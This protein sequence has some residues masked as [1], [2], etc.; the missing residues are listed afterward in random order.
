MKK[1]I[2]AGAAFVLLASAGIA[3]AQSSPALGINI[4]TSPRIERGA[5]DT[6]VTL[7]SLSA[8]DSSTAV[9]VPSLRIETSFGNGAMVGDITDC[10]LRTVNNLTSALNNGSNAVGITSGAT[11]IPLDTPF[12]VAMGTTATLALT[13]DV[14]STAALNGTITLGV[15]PSS[16]SA[17]VQ[18]SSTTVSVSTGRTTTGSDGPLSGTAQIVADATPSTPTTPTVPGVP[19]TGS[20][21]TQ[22]LIMLALAGVVA[23]GGIFLARRIAVEG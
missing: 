23:L 13:C 16:Q 5:Q 9:Q 15:A 19:N 1:H 21:T 18:G 14:A 12:V 4:Y 10:R 20:G 6:L 22:N 3:A 11:V 2:A 17:T 8:R 7:V